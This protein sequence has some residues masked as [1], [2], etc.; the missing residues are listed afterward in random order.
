[1]KPMHQ[2]AWLA[3]FGLPMAQPALRGQ[4]PP[5]QPI[6]AGQ[7]Q[8]VPVGPEVLLIEEASLPLDPS[9]QSSS[10]PAGST[11]F[12]ARGA[13][14]Y[15][16]DASPKDN[17]I[18]LY[19]FTVAQGETLST[20]VESDSADAVTQRFGLLSGPTFTPAANSKGQINRINRLSRQ[21]R[22]TKVEFKNTEGRPFPLL[23]IVY[24]LV[25]HPYKVHITRTPAK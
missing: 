25:G 24:G 10:Q 9:L 19:R 1:M 7:N 11:N 13:A 12:A 4:A 20:Q 14:T 18:K 6:T 2:I 17:G 8:M 3:L 16:E 22:T 23:L 21:Q 15:A 5:S